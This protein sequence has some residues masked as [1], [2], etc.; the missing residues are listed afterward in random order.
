M[1]CPLVGSA[2]TVGWSGRAEVLRRR[3]SCRQHTAGRTN[4]TLLTLLPSDT[5]CPCAFNC[6]LPTYMSPC[7]CLLSRPGQ[8]AFRPAVSQSGGSVQDTPAYERECVV[9]CRQLSP[10]IPF[11]CCHPSEKL[12]TQQETSSF[13]TC[14]KLFSFPDLFDLALGLGCTH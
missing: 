1:P 4:Q 7:L 8:N 9:Y 6:F 13:Q 11:Q 10:F 3:R 5:I 14:F 12:C 2:S